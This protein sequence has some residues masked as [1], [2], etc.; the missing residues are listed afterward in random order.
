MFAFRL[1]LMVLTEWTIV[2]TVEAATAHP[3]VKVFWSII[4]VPGMV[5]S[6]P[7]F[8][9]VVMAFSDL[10]KWLTRRNLVL[11][12]ILPVITVGM[13]ATNSLHHWLW[14]SFSLDTTT[15]IMT[16]GQG[17]WF[18]VNAAYCY[19]LILAGTAILVWDAIRFRQLHRRQAVALLLAGAIP[20]AANAM[21]IFHIGSPIGLDW[22]P[23]AFSLT[24]FT[25]FL[26]IFRFQFLELVPVAHDRVFDSLSDGV[27]IIDDKGRMAD[28]NPTAMRL[29]EFTSRSVIGQPAVSV[30]AA[31]P[32]LLKATEGTLEKQ[33][34]LDTG[35]TPARFLDLHISPLLDTRGRMTGKIVLFRDVTEQNLADERLVEA[36]D[37][38]QK[39]FS[40][41]SL[42][43][44][45]YK[46]NGACV[47]ANEAAARIT[48]AGVQELLMQDFRHIPSWE[49]S[50]LLQMA[51]AALATG[52]S[53]QG[54]VHHLL[55]FGREIW[56]NCF[57][58][59]FSSNGEPHLL[60]VFDDVTERKRIEDDEHQQRILAEALRDTAEALNSSLDLDVI[61]ERV[62]I[63]IG[64]VMPY[65]TS[66]IYLFDDQ[67]KVQAVRLH[68]ALTQHSEEVTQN[69]ERES[70]NFRT[71]QV[72]RETVQA[73]IIP[74]VYQDPDW[75]V[76]PGLEWLR[77]H[78]S[79]PIMVKGKVI[80]AIGL[81]SRTAGFFS[82]AS[83][84]P[85]LPFANEAGIAIENARLYAEVQRLA[86][87]D[88]LTGL[89]NF[90]ALMELGPREFERAR[91]FNRTLSVLF[92]DIDHFGEFNNRY[93][94]ATGNLVLHAVAQH[95]LSGARAMDLVARYGGEEF[96][97]LLP[98][99][100][101]AIAATV[102]ERLRLDVASILVPTQ[103]GELSVTVSI[104]AAELSAEMPNLPALIDAAN[105]AEHLAKERG[106]NLVVVLPGPQPV[107]RKG[108]VNSTRLPPDQ[109]PQ[110]G[111][112][113]EVDQGGE[114]T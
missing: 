64:R 107:N 7:L 26:T 20:W 25:F 110:A 97:I 100:S 80:G 35:S 87:T 81:S 68:R 98:E 91:R 22:T 79:A 41:S 85:L 99:T 34:M 46:A 101:V 47:L 44:L 49:G 21:Y 63:N 113:A 52:S 30:L 8:L 51:E 29:L 27:I 60:L 75:V 40:A 53:Q 14:S 65:D 32:S 11:L 28:L 33:L 93:S 23:V 95:L 66:E 84:R 15:N 50:G 70:H 37:L 114:P 69:I 104:G 48:S 86:I 111:T 90:R 12:S 43:I 88:E 74:D 17:P 38:N 3:L 89:Y 82:E 2:A 54:E 45:V 62:L 18:W 59:T 71:L 78:V 94:H 39:I 108:E 56:I 76:V 77:S 67:G 6:P 16:Y 105:Q 5:A 24:S 106:R 55:T 36:L 83:C 1:L 10:D 31:W 112:L 19:L 42:G 92:L 9:V 109:D 4:E 102:A 13:A 57:F 72:V 73:M 96:I 103:F 58:T 61:L